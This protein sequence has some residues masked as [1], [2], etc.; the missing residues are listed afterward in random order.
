MCG[1]YVFRT[2]YAIQA[3]AF[4]AAGAA[5]RVYAGQKGLEESHGEFAQMALNFAYG[6]FGAVAIAFGPDQLARLKTA[7]IISYGEV[8]PTESPEAIQLLLRRSE[9]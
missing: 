2:R 5:F 6:I 7:I 9:I 4:N 3:T 1:N 8:I